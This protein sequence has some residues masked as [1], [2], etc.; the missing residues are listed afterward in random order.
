MP[1]TKLLEEELTKNKISNSKDYSKIL[2]RINE[3]ITGD[4][5]KDEAMIQF[6]DRQ[7]GHS[8]FWKLQNDDDLQKVIKY[9][10]IPLL[11]DYFYGDYSK[12]REIL[13]NKKDGEFTI[14]GKDN[15]TTDLV[16]DISQSHELRKKLLEILE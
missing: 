4:G 16:N 6:R 14:I 2:K 13:G 15:R 10:I 7:I 8:Y 5:K 1:D 3:K 12:I 9:D 11:Q